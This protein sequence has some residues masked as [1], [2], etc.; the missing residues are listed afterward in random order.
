MSTRSRTVLLVSGAIALLLLFLG[1]GAWVGWNGLHSRLHNSSRPA[2]TST[3]NDGSGQMPLDL[4]SF[5]NAELDRGW[6]PGL[7]PESNLAAMPRG[8]QEFGGVVFNII[9]PV[10]LQ[11]TAWRAKEWSF[12]KGAE[13]I[14]VGRTF[15]KIFLLH[16]TRGAFPANGTVAARLVI[17]YESGQDETIRIRAGEH[18]LNWIAPLTKMPTDTNTVLA[19][20]GK[21][22]VSGQRD[23][24][25]R[26]WRTLF[27]NP[28]PDE[29]VV[30]VD[31]VSALASCGPLLL[32]VTVE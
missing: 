3:L 7:P 25:I 28:H 24:K 10:Q 21:N 14:P 5:T 17:H 30:S 8:R 22:P 4:S 29:K 20:S 27:E 6:V 19:W 11:G 13:G 2:N 26:I 12:P 32:G 31:Y 18:L 1:I 15:S 9:G 23:E 16:A